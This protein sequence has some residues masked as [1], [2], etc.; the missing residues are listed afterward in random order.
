MPLAAAPVTETLA[1][2][3]AMIP[4]RLAIDLADAD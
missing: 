1:H 4:R 2:L 3:T